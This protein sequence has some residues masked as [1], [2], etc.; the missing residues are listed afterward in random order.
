MIRYADGEWTTDLETMTCQKIN[1]KRTISFKRRGKVRKRKVKYM[2]I[3]LMSVWASNSEDKP[4][5]K[6]ILIF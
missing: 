3:K 2:P 1:T 4:I 6:T 5:Q